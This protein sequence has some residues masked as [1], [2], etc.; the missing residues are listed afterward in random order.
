VALSHQAALL[1]PHV[2]KPSKV[3]LLHHLV[4]SQYAPTSSAIGFHFERYDTNI[5]TPVIRSALR[6]LETRKEG[7][8]TVYLPS[9]HHYK[10]INVLRDITDVE[11]HIFSKQATRD[12]TYGSNVK[13]FPIDNKTFLK[14]LISSE[15]I[16]CG[17]GFE[18]PAEALY[19]RKKLLVIPMKGQFEQRYNAKALKQ[20]GVPVIRQFRK[21]ENH[22][23]VDWI[24]DKKRV[25]VQ[26]PDMTEEIL[27]MALERAKSNLIEV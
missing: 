14:S 3:D 12:S 15:G 4:L 17:A 5:F 7:H 26:Y 9:Y 10:I 27:D 19:L 13:V 25:S 2:P 21:S 8:Y 24:S 23:I 1:S 18:T 16:I 6:K 20:L 22:K 11:W